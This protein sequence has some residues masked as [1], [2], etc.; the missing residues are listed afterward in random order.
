[1]HLIG[2]EEV[3]IKW[4]ILFIYRCNPG[5]RGGNCDLSYDLCDLTSPCVGPNSTCTLNNGQP[6]CD[7]SSGKC[8]EKGTR[9][10]S[11][12]LVVYDR[13]YTIT[14]ASVSLY[15]VGHLFLKWESVFLLRHQKCDFLHHQT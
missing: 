6:D 5:Y 1:M 15:G 12:P 9:K 14:N 4:Y 7:C 8:K 10:H 11:D 13:H 3:E 2:L